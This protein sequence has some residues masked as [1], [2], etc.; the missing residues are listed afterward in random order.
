[1]KLLISAYAC[2]PHRGSEHGVGWNWITQA[3][4]AGHRVTAL[5]SPAHHDAIQRACSQD[6]DLEGITWCYPR[7]RGWTLR[8]GIEPR[9]E[10][11]YNALWQISAL[12]HAKKLHCKTNFDAVHHLTWGGVRAPTRLGRLGPPLIIGPIGGGEIAP[13]GLRDAFRLR[14]KITEW[15]RDV[16]TRTIGVNPLVGHGLRKASMIVAR[17]PETAALIQSAFGKSSVQMSELGLYADQIDHAPLRSFTPPRLLCASRLLYWKGTHLAIAAFAELARAM[18]DARLT[19]VGEGPEQP[20]LRAAASDEGVLD[21]V[22]FLNW[23]PQGDL[24]QL[25]REHNLF[26]FPSLH[27]SGGS[28]VLEALSKGLPILCLDIGGPRQLVTAQSGVVINTNGQNSPNVVAAMAQS[29]IRL[30]ANPSELAE[31]SV[32]ASA[33]AQDFLIR[34]RVTAFYAMVAETIGATKA[35]PT[36]A[37]ASASPATPVPN[38]STAHVP[39]GIPNSVM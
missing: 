2:A 32:G 1:M 33:R 8:Q 25:Y 31:L 27:D 24:F 26:V 18:P 30:F 29:M 6:F 36:K 14:G 39:V 23:V 5:V 37:S 16:S 9:R 38:R 22:T 12:H 11:S 10:R 19:I 20:H 28:V 21:K 17:T 3:H 4:R 7:V 13:T 35:V 34:D 15:I